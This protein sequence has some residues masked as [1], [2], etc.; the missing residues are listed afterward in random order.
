MRPDFKGPGSSSFDCI[1]RVR[2]VKFFFKLVMETASRLDSHWNIQSASGPLPLTLTYII[3][4]NP[5]RWGVLDP[6]DSQRI[7]SL[8][9]L[10]S[11]SVVTCVA[12]CRAVSPNLKSS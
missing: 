10:S 4:F 2:G 7:G 11:S 3:S 9:D 1:I 5:V 6:L 12:S 8:E